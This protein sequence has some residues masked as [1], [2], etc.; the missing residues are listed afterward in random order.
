VKITSTQITANLSA[1]GTVAQ[2]AL[3]PQQT[4]IGEDDGAGT[5]LFKETNRYIDRWNKAED[6]LA[7]LLHLQ[8][9][10]PI[11]TVTT[12]GGVLDKGAL[13]DEG[14]AFNH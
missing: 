11:P 5:I 2:K 7:S 10:R 13:L 9:T 3:D 14:P 1:I 8:F 4:T 12:I 6:E